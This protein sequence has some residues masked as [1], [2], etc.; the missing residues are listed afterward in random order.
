MVNLINLHLKRLWVIT[1][2]VNLI[3]H[4]GKSKGVVT[5]NTS[6]ALCDHKRVST[7]TGPW[8]FLIFFLNYGCD[9][10][11]WLVGMASEK[12]FCNKP[13]ITHGRQTVAINS[14]FL[15]RS[16]IRLIPVHQLELPH[17]SDSKTHSP[18]IKYSSQTKLL[19]LRKHEAVVCHLHLKYYTCHDAST[20][21]QFSARIINISFYILHGWT[22]SVVSRGLLKNHVGLQWLASIYE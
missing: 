16:E 4:L 17:S 15:A 12:A 10:L 2:S 3:C 19:I 6:I 9:F 11:Q 8:H 18:Y 21:V 5:I 13:R 14:L 1:T 7:M 22:C 20:S